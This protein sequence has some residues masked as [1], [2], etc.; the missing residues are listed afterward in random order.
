MTQFIIKKNNQYYYRI[1][2]SGRARSVFY[3]DDINQ[4]DI[5]EDEEIAND[6]LELARKRDIYNK[7][8]K[9]GDVYKVIPV[10]RETKIINL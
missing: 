5:F 7:K 1:H 2:T 3:T 10:K 6:F 9:K 8:S 4:S